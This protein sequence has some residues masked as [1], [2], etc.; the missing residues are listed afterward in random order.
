MKRNGRIRRGGGAVALLALACSLSA[1]SLPGASDGQAAVSKP[2]A[3]TT[4][5]WVYTTRTTDEKLHLRQDS[6]GAISGNGTSAVR[7]TNGQ[8][9]HSSITVHSGKA[10]GGRLTLML[11]VTQL[12][13]GSGLT[14]VENLRCGVASHA[15]TCRMNLPLYRVQNAPQTFR[16]A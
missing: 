3:S 10:Q 16:K 9:D 12:D 8:V 7:V 13:W 11:Y 6:R 1:C 15:L 4:G 14:A 2:A 5:A